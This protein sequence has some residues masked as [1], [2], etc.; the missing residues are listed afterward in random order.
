[1]IIKCIGDPVS[2]G[3]AVGAVGNTGI[4]SGPHLH[5]EGLMKGPFFFIHEANLRASLMAAPV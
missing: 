3:D 2:Q 5:F 1:M 4:G